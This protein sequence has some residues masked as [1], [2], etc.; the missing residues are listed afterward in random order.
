MEKKNIFLRN[1]HPCKTSQILTC[2]PGTE[3]CGLN[4]AKLVPYAPASWPDWYPLGNCWLADIAPESGWPAAEVTRRDRIDLSDIY[5]YKTFLWI[6]QINLLSKK[7]PCLSYWKL[8]FCRFSLQMINGFIAI[9]SEKS[10]NHIIRDG[11]W[12][13]LDPNHDFTKLR[14]K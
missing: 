10:I 1:I 8:T 5:K 12:P 6:N 14:L 3:Y 2:C 9:I 13:Y 7:Y 11:L 4:C